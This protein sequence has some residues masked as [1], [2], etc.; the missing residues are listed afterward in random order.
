MKNLLLSLIL[1]LTPIHHSHDDD[2]VLLHQ[3]TTIATINHD[4]FTSSLTDLPLVNDEMYGQLV[5]KLEQQINKDPIN[6]YINQ[7]NEII[8]GQPG[9]VLN[10]DQLTKDLYTYFFNHQPL[11]LELPIKT[12]HPRVSGELLADIYVK[13]IGSYMTYYNQHKS[14]RSKNIILATKAINNHVVFQGEVFSFNKV[15]GKRTTEKGYLSAPIIIKGELYD[16]VGG[17]ICQV[18]STLFNAVDSAGVKIV[19][20]YSHSRKVPYVPPG[21]DA[22]VSWYGPDFTFKNV[23]NQPILIR[24]EAKDGKVMIRIFSSE[25]INVE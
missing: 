20:R 4:A 17:G 25:V 15:V 21:R 16:G 18:S 1:M 3:G 14:E 22:T 19:Q 24:A 10:S 2:L 8:Q 23:Y 11:S 7:H 13:Q 5:A 12:I 9:F 6:A